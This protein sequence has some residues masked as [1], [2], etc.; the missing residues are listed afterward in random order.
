MAELANKI[1]VEPVVEQQ[2]EEA[3]IINIYKNEGEEVTDATTDLSYN[4]IYTVDPS[5]TNFRLK[6]IESN[7]DTRTNIRLKKSVLKDG[8]INPILVNNQLEILDGQHRYKIALENNINFDFV[9]RELTSDAAKVIIDLNNSQH[10]WNITDR[11][12]HYSREGNEEYQKL[13]RYMEAYSNLISR[14]TITKIAS[15]IWALGHATN[16]G[17]RTG[18]FKNYKNVMEEFYSFISDVSVHFDIKPRR[19]MTSALYALWAYSNFDED[20]FMRK[21]KDPDIY[22]K[23]LHRW[24]N[25]TDASTIFT[26][27]VIRYNSGLSDNS[28]KRILTVME[29]DANSNRLVYKPKKSEISSDKAKVN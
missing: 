5:N 11:V 12:L 18:N 19:G 8:I 4:K 28:P 3:K 21:M 17:Y 22:N 6:F 13:Y 29:E 14:S 20:R 24:N 25:H 7:R 16:D 15:G 9:I 26:E 23:S 10:G 2:E 1:Q 27:I